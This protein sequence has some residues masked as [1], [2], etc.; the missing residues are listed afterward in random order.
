LLQA[1]LQQVLGTHVKQ[2]GSVVD[3]T[4]LRFDF[5]HFTGMAP[6]ERAEVERIVNHQIVRNEAVATE[7]MD[8]DQALK[9][10]AMA[11]FGEKYGDTVRVVTIPGFSRELCGGTHVQR[12]GDIGVARITYEGSSSAGVRR[13]EMVTGPEAVITHLEAERGDLAAELDKARDQQKTLER[14]VARMKEQIAQ[15]KSA[16][17]EGQAR[18][19]KGVQVLAARVDG[20]DRA[21]LRNLADALRNKFKTAVVALASAE[22]GQIA[23]ITAVTKD[24]TGKVHAGKLLGTLAAAVGGKGGGRPDLAEGGGNDPAALDAALEQVYASVEGML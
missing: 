8:L 1:A 12:T 5:T 14:E 24:I 7:V 10:G 23:L 22:D 18:A 13:I 11:L 21:Q 6:E 17:V 15:S 19:I 16:S 3:P 2:A 9:T 4:R 20:L